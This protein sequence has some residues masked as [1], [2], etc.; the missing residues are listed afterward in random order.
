M[1]G[2]DICFC[3]DFRSEH[4]PTCFCGCGEFRFANRASLND[5]LTWNRYHAN[6]CF[7][8]VSGCDCRRVY[9]GLNAQRR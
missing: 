7:G 4:R 5:Q 3:G 8:N 6:R 2:S 9:E 1:S